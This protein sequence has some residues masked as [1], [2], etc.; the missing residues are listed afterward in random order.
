MAAFRH[1]TLQTASEKRSLICFISELGRSLFVAMWAN[2]EVNG[3]S[4]NRL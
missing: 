1:E 4:P 2:E 3:A